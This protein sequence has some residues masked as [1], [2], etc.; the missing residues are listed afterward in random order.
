MRS[1]YPIAAARVKAGQLK[2]IR[3]GQHE[4]LNTSMWYYYI[5]T[6]DSK[7]NEYSYQGLAAMETQLNSFMNFMKE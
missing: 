3:T 4:I 5:L 7:H 1:S 6:Y 2:N